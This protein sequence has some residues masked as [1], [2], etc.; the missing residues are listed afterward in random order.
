L[1]V[2]AFMALMVLG[3]EAVAAVGLVLQESDP[4]KKELVTGVMVFP[5]QLWDKIYIGLVAGVVDRGWPPLVLEVVDL[6]EVA[7]A[8]REITLAQPWA[9]AVAGL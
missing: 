5:F 2:L 4:R 3:A 9:R 7:E 1:E 6:V 8:S